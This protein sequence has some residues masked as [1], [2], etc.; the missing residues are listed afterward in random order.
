MSLNPRLTADRGGALFTPI[1]LL[2]LTAL[3]T[4]LGGCGGS[5]GQAVQTNVDRSEDENT[6]GVVYKGPSPTT[7]DVQNFKINVWDNLASEER[8]GACHIEGG[9][10]PEFVRADTPSSRS[11]HVVSRR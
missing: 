10:S 9:Q 6:S 4:S 1:T 8:C 2:L 3:A 5:S 11:N 7:E